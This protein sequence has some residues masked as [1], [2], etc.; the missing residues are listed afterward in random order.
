MPASAK[1]RA[2]STDTPAS[3]GRHGPGEITSRS[4]AALEQLVDRRGVV[5]HDL[6]LR[7]QLTQVLDEV[8]GEA[9]VVVDHQ[10]LHRLGI[11]P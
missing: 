3:T 11:A 6:G 7:A 10:H 8:V 4:G 5:A 9:V 1:R 2:A